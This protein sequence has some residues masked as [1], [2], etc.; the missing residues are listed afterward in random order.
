ME[1]DGT[2]GSSEGSGNEGPR[3]RLPLNSKRLKRSQLECLAKALDLPTSASSDELRQPIDDKLTDQGK[4]ARNV[5]VVSDDA[6]PASRFALEDEE[7]EFLE[8]PADSG[9][10]SAGDSRTSPTAE[11]DGGGTSRG[12]QESEVASLTAALEEARRQTES[13][14]AQVS[15]LRHQLTEEKTRFREMWRSNCRCL[16]EYDSVIAE[17]DV[18]IEEL[19][20]SL[21]EAT[22]LS[23]HDPVE[24]SDNSMSETTQ[25]L[26]LPAPRSLAIQWL[27]TPHPK[28]EENLT[29]GKQTL[30][31][32]GENASSAKSQAT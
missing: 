21:Q 7:G 9:G 5:Q 25:P 20:H 4:E 32:V 1:T 13:L 31:R 26:P 10:G 17:K 16:A 28:E 19:K 3:V 23:G 30:R 6:T 14:Q 29:Q 8:V 18:E 12:S 27:L 22:S 15:E 24:A 2:G 11:P